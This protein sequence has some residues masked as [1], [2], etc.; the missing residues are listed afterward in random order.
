MS[1]HKTHR[2]WSRHTCCSFIVD[3]LS[4]ITS[5]W[6][7]AAAAGC[8]R[9]DAFF[10]S[11]LAR[12]V[13]ATRPPFAGLYV[14]PRNK[15]DM[16]DGV[17]TDQLSHNHCTDSHCSSHIVASCVFMLLVPT[18]ITRRR[19]W[20]VP[21][22]MSTTS[23]AVRQGQ[24]LCQDTPHNVS[25]PVQAAE[26]RQERRVPATERRPDSVCIVL[27]IGAAPRVNVDFRSR[28]GAPFFSVSHSI[29]RP[30]DHRRQG[31]AHGSLPQSLLPTR[32]PSTM[33]TS[34]CASSWVSSTIMSMSSL[35]RT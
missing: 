19:R 15:D 29:T 21:S 18:T 32:V 9:S 3:V 27:P 2:H 6:A 25:L 16:G 8:T 12:P 17:P 4:L 35:G 5:W 13:A 1:L 28:C 10:H 11:F 14:I 23:Q 22:A 20:R 34:P 30:A 26:D 33:S 7:A 31:H 24:A